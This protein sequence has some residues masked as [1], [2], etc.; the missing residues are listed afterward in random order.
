M[1]FDALKENK[2]IRDNN[3]FLKAEIYRLEEHTKLLERIRDHYVSLEICNKSCEYIEPW[4]VSTINKL[5]GEKY[6][7]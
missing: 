6:E 5:I 7:D 2:L 4:V 3:N 1:K